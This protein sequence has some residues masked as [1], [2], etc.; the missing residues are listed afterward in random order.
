MGW[1]SCVSG[2]DM[3]LDTEIQHEPNEKVYLIALLII[4]RR[5]VF[6]NAPWNT[7][8]KVSAHETYST[9]VW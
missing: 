9:K 1:F 5:S 4:I 8:E 3:V 7:L 2:Y 6:T